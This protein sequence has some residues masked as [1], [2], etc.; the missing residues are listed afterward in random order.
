MKNKIIPL[1]IPVFFTMSCSKI[2]SSHNNESLLVLKGKSVNIVPTKANIPLSEGLKLGAFVL[3]VTTGSEETLSSAIIENKLLTVDEGGNIT[4][5]VIYLNAGKDYDVYAYSPRVTGAPLNPNAIP[6]THGTDVLYSDV[7][8]TLRGVS[9][10]INTV[11]MVFLHKMSQIKFSLTDDR[12]QITKNAYPF[13]GATF[14]VTGFV[15]DF[16]LNLETGE[17][18][19]Q[20]VDG[21]VKITEQ[22]IPVC[23][24][25]STSAMTL[26]IKVTIPGAISGE[27]TFTGSVTATFISGNSY[28]YNI[29]ISTTSLEITGSVTDWATVPT[30]DVIVTQSIRS[31]N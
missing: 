19:R 5:D 9:I 18:T 6:Y 12:D 31:R 26:P 1:I 11:D 16:T 30:D 14:E 17:I 29:K 22:N 28:S 3:N 13:S 24:A 10:G 15:K 20:A 21:T 23:F 25:P 2:N 8:R 27:Q 7:N 4:G